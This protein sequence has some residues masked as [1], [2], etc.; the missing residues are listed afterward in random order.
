MTVYALTLWIH[1][2]LRWLIVLV[3]LL[4]LVRSAIGW[5]RSADWGEPDERLHAIFI[6]LLD[7]QFT[8][9]IVL[10][11][12]LSPISAAFFAQPGIGMK[13]PVLRFFGMEH[14]LAMILAVSIAHVGRARSKKALTP[15]LRQRRV[16][17]STL[18]VLLLIA[19]SIPWPF[20]RHGRPLLR[21]VTRSAVLAPPAS[22][23]H[24]RPLLRL[25]AES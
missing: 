7:T 8:L 14:P 20:L 5:A 17:T 2:Y 19:V 18:V 10:Y 15:Q 21:G 24:N 16:C 6:A 23:A 12:F 1:S 3:V 25:D 13:E 4:L 22:F 9:G 11:L